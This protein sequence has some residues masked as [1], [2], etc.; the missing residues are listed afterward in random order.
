VVSP[1]WRRCRRREIRGAAVISY[2]QDR[3]VL[4]LIVIFPGM[5]LPP[6]SRMGRVR[7]LTPAQGRFHL[8]HAIS[9]S[10]SENE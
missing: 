8:R 6:G 9:P 2:I 5:T 1:S 4:A 3:T 7:G 10:N